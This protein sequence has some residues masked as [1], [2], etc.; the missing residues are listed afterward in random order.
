MSRTSSGINV[1]KFSCKFEKKQSWFQLPEISYYILLQLFDKTGSVGH[2][3][4]HDLKNNQWELTDDQSMCR[5]LSHF[6]TSTGHPLEDIY[7]DFYCYSDKIVIDFDAT[8]IS[9]FQLISILICKVI[10]I[11]IPVNFLSNNNKKVNCKALSTLSISNQ[12]NLSLSLRE[13]IL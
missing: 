1:A 7:T 9:S 8:N 13:L 3:D 5:K 4:N 6:S 12:L 2:R 10:S 11:F